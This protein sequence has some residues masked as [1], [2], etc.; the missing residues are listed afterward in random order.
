[1]STSIWRPVRAELRRI[2]MTVPGAS[3]YH[4]EMQGYTPVVGVPYLKDQIEKGNASTATLGTTGLIREDGIYL[5]DV[6]WPTAGVKADGEDLADAIRCEF[7]HAREIASAGGDFIKGRV[8]SS[9]SRTAIPG[10]A[11]T[12]FPVRIQFFVYRKT[13]QGRAA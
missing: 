3:G 5:V 9:S 12:T 10:E 7:W 13:N 11:W 6:K 4:F 8:E 2:L 1:M